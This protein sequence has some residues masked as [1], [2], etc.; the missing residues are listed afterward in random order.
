MILYKTIRTPNAAYVYDRDRHCILKVSKEEY[1]SLL[2]QE[3]DSQNGVGPV[4]AKYQRQGFLRENI[5]KKIE[6][7]ATLY[8]D[9]YMNHRL[10]HLILQATQ[11]CNLRCGYC[12]YSGNHRNRTHTN[13]DMSMETARRAID[14]LME[15]SDES[16]EL[17]ITF[18]GGE[19]LLQFDWIRQ[20][21][22]YS[23]EKAGD[24]K[25]SFNMTSNGTLLT[26]KVAQFILQHDFHLLIS[27]D[28]MQEEHDKSRRYADGTGSFEN[29]MHNLREC[30]R[31]YPAFAERLSFN[32]VINHSSDYKRVRRFFA[33]DTY[34]ATADVMLNLVDDSDSLIEEEFSDSFYSATEYERFLLYLSAL[35]KVERPRRMQEDHERLLTDL[36]KLYEE[37]RDQEHRSYEVHHHNGPCIPGHRLLVNVDG[38]F[39]P[40]ERVCEN[41]AAMRIGNLE[42]GFDRKKAE[43]MLNI[44]RLTEAECKDCWCLSLCSVCAKTAEKDGS[45]SREAKL[46]ICRYEKDGAIEKLQEI[47]LLKENGYHF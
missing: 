22:A 36:E 41:A 1:E 47:C 43:A 7:P 18:Y 31:Q 6:H 16:K 15:R 27:L 12:T 24:K 11:R 26:P 17:Y 33:E 13:K 19:P 25:V 42:Q 3:D 38:D 32:A 34:F 4:F 35:H 5:V 45:L 40:C 44:G 37:L 2:Q 46:N 9:H 39:F 20:C 10:S 29:I 21:V 8:L 28:G 14:F 30:I 23:L